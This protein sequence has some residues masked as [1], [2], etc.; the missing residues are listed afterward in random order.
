VTLVGSKGESRKD[1]LEELKPLCAKEKSKERRGR[2]PGILLSF[3]KRY[4][5]GGTKILKRSVGTGP[6]AR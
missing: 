2:R 6:E 3:I 4:T 1:K 5:S